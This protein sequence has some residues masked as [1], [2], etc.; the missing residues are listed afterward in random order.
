MY[1]HVHRY[2]SFH[3]SVVAGRD[4]DA[5]YHVGVLLLLPSERGS[6][7]VALHLRGLFVWSACSADERADRRRFS[8]NNNSR[9]LAYHRRRS[10]ACPAEAFHRRT[11]VCG[12]CRAVAHRGG[13]QQSRKPYGGCAS[14]ESGPR[15]LL[16]LLHERAPAALHRQ[17]LSGGLRH[18]PAACVSRPARSM[19]FPLELFPSDG[20]QRDSPASEELEPRGASHALSCSLGGTGHSLFLLL[21]DPGV[22]HDAFVSC[23]RAPDR[24]RGREGGKQMAG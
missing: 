9:L 23:L 10:Q 8:S 20:H 7:L 4:V 13:T 15:V 1:R 22:L 3:S 2:L 19:A 18:G 16:V 14:S 21:D 12:G 17:T 6:R 11:A 5:V 24:F